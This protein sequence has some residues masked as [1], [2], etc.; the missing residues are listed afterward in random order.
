M[1]E[2][3]GGGGGGSSSSSTSTS[4][5]QTSVDV[6]SQVQVVNQ[7]DVSP[8]V[9]AVQRVTDALTGISANETA[10]T[11]ATVGAITSVM[12]D[13]SAAQKAVAGQIGDTVSTV[14]DKITAAM[15]KAGKD[16][17]ILGCLTLAAVY[18]GGRK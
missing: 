3:F 15:D 16:N 2:V 14:A 10:R 1:G 13:Q 11:Q 6:T 4:T 7:V 12:A 8:L 5:N 17:L 9:P 18:F